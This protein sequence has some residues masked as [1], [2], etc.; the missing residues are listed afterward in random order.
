MSLEQA[1]TDVEQSL[2]TVSDHLLAAD[3]L[4]LERSSAHLR[5][6]VTGLSA[7]L[8]GRPAL[9]PALAQRV[10]EVHAQLALQREGLARLA[11]ATERQAAVV[12]PSVRDDATYAQAVGVR[13]VSG[14]GARIYRSAS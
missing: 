13:A 2:Q 1:L 4:A 12:L 8:A 14:A 6:A 10:Q 9:S 11:A 5:E 3:A 7:V